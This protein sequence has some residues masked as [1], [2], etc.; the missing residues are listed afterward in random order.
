MMT[1]GT[2]VQIGATSAAA[3]L[4]ISSTSVRAGSRSDRFRDHFSAPLR[5]EVE[6]A[7]AACQEELEAFAGA[8]YQAVDHGSADPTGS[9]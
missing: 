5:A 9:E 1:P 7:F 3:S 2:T 8:V 4:G 6:Q